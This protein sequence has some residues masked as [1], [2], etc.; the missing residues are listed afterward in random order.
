MRRIC[1]E[2]A[3]NAYGAYMD[4]AWNM[5]GILIENMH[6]ICMEYAGNMFKI[7]WI[8]HGTCAE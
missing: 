8:M 3:W 2:Y 6:G 7:A 5:Y 1:V 4:D